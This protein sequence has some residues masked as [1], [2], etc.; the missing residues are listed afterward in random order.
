MTLLE[1]LESYR[2]ELA[3]GLAR[4]DENIAVE[5]KRIAALNNSQPE[6]QQEEPLG[7]GA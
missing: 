7:V 2:E 5:R 4:I 1:I 3:A 6:T